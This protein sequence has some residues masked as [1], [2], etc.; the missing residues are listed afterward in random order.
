M[1]PLQARRYAMDGTNA[2]AEKKPNTFAQR[3]VGEMA[4]NWPG[5]TFLGLLAASPG[6]AVGAPALALAGAVA[7]PI[8]LGV[9]HIREMERAFGPGANGNGHVG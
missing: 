4:L 5:Y 1:S 8:G 3:V 7:A 9:R 6:L 2:P